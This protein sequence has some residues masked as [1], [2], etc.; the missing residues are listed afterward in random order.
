MKTPKEALK[1]LEYE[2]TNKDQRISRDELELDINIIK[3]ALTNKSEEKM[4]RE[5]EVQNFTKFF[6]DVIKTEKLN[7][8]EIIER[9]QSYH[10]GVTV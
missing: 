1:E 5:N 4:I 7:R 8:D 10:K 2:A 9:L 3:S 6:V